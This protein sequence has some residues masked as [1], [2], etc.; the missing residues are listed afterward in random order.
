MTG[1]DPAALD[2][3]A[4]KA[5]TALWAGEELAEGTL[6]TVAEC[7]KI[8][9][10][11]LAPPLPVD[12]GEG[13]H[14]LKITLDDGAVVSELICPESGCEPVDGEGPPAPCWLRTWA[15][16]EDL[17]ANYVLGRA[18]LGTFAID[19]T[20]KAD[21]PDIKF[22]APA[23]SP[24]GVRDL[25]LTAARHLRTLPAQPERRD[26]ELAGELE[27]AAF[28]A[29]YEKPAPAGDAAAGELSSDPGSN[30]TEQAGD[31][32]REALGRALFAEAYGGAL[33]WDA[34]SD[35]T[36]VPHLDRAQ[37]LVAL[38]PSP[39]PGAGD[40]MVRAE[41]ARDDAWTVCSALNSA[42]HHGAV[43]PAQYDRLYAVF[44]KAAAIDD[45][46]PRDTEETR[47]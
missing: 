9:L 6:Q 14:L 28:G 45:D 31:E 4:M 10:A 21:A 23:S 3:A 39:L 40:G 15:E 17:A 46:A 30:R 26:V 13:R 43:K 11:D 22:V 16:N 29:A 41:I 27:A 42:L 2:R 47:G 44:A 25:L 18:V 5:A 7:M 12:G 37:R 35:A 36:R 8:G 1:I 38:L 24:S 32:A 19:A 33:D 20:W 34:V